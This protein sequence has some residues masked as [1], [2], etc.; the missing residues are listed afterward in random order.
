M[1]IQYALTRSEM[2]GSFFRSLAASR[3]LL[4][5]VFVMPIVLTAFYLFSS[6]GFPRS[7]T[8]E[9]ETTASAIF[10]G[11]FLFMPAFIF[12]S[13]KT[14]L[15]TLTIS[16]DGIH[17]EIG[18]MSGERSWPQIK[19]VTDQKSFILIVGRNGNSFFIPN[20]AFS[21]MEEK[22]EL[23]ARIKRWREAEV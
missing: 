18:G 14:S 13:A 11:F 23:I 21:D 22:T 4:L 1:T 10:F 19:E 8:V 7:L 2:L 3:R 16:S 5:T 6:K 17:T 12:V 15:R 9:N 20:R